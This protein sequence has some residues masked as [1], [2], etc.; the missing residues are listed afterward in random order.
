[1]HKV[2]QFATRAYMLAKMVCKTA[3]RIL[4]ALIFI[5][6]VL[7]AIIIGLFGALCFG[8]GVLIENKKGEQNP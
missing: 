4:R 8:L 2:M 7:A 5:L 3:K 6:A 1:M